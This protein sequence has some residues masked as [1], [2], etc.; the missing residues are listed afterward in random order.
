MMIIMDLTDEDKRQLDIL[1]GRDKDQDVIAQHY[2]E[3]GARGYF[4]RRAIQYV[5]V[6]GHAP[7]ALVRMLEDFALERGNTGD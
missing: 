3:C 6:A 7:A 5:R 1:Q 2:R 4:A